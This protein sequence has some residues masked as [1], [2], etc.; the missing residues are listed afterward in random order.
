MKKLF[1]A[2]VA[3][4]IVAVSCQKD[5]TS[6]NASIENFVFEEEV[7]P[8]A[9]SEENAISH[10]MSVLD[11]IAAETRGGGKKNIVSISTVNKTDV[12]PS[13]TRSTE[14]DIPEDLLYIVSFGEGNGS[15]VLSADVRINP[16][17]AILDQTV[18]TPE[19]FAN[20]SI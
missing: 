7:S 6:N 11:Q 9:V 4:A 5:A 19:D 18:L 16:I 15:A 8:Y 1:F 2:L 3:M 14:C 17:L 20:N 12:L 10:L 13:E